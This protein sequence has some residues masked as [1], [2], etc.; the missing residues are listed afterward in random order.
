MPRWEQQA[1]L[2]C[3]TLEILVNS[4]HLIFVEPVVMDEAKNKET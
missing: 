2:G 3:N 4:G 1:D